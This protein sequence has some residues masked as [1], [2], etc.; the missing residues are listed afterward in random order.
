M[1]YE[2]DLPKENKKQNRLFK[3]LRSNKKQSILWWIVGLL[4]GM[5]VFIILKSWGIL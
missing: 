2:F 5:F 4:S 1:G 3:Q